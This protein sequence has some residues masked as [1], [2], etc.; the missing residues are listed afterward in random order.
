MDEQGILVRTSAAKV[1]VEYR[2]PV[3]T[4]SG[5]TYSATATY[6][7]GDVIY[8]TDGDYHLCLTATSAGESPTSAAA[9]WEVQQVPAFLRESLAT[10][11]CAEL[12]LQDGQEGRYGRMTSKARQILD[13]KVI[14]LGNK[15]GLSRSL[16][17]LSRASTAA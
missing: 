2:R 9:K 17:V 1:W 7:P 11:V 8:F 10:A 5:S 3:P 4:Y 16:P 14:N 12:L 15:Q 13:Q 6:S